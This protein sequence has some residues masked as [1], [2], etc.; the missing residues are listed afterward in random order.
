MGSRRGS[1]VTLV[2]GPLIGGE[3]SPLGKTY[4]SVSVQEN[5]VKRALL[6]GTRIKVQ[7]RK[8]GVLIARAG[9]NELSGGIMLD[10]GV[11][12]F[13]RAIQTQMGCGPELEAQDDWFF[14]FL[15]HEPLW[16]VDGDTF[17]LTDG[18]TTLVLLD[19]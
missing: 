19:R 3:G 1:D 15:L 18:R 16:T 8:D 2:Y 5:G 14:G 11:L 17:T 13:E 4:L 10:D 12:R 7:I 6:P 9:C